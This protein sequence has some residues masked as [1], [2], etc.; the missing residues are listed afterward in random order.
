MFTHLRGAG[1]RNHNR[2]TASPKRL[3]RVGV[4]VS[5]LRGWI[6]VKWW[7]RRM[8]TM[9]AP[10]SYVCWF[11]NPMDTIVLSIINHVF[12]SNEPTWLSRGPHSV[13]IKSLAIK[14]VTTCYYYCYIVVCYCMLHMVMLESSVM[15]LCLVAQ[16]PMSHLCLHWRDRKVRILKDT[17]NG[18]PFEFGSKVFKAID[19]YIDVYIDI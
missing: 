1:C 9:W 18:S 2:L 8:V 16:L 7:D 5:H 11:I 15:P 19:L 14:T 12:W 17:S 3:P 6:V 13:T 4:Q 10:P